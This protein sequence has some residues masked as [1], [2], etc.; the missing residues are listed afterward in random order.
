M[1]SALYLASPTGETMTIRP[2]SGSARAFVTGSGVLML[3]ATGKS[4][5]R[6]YAASMLIARFGASSCENPTFTVRAAG[7][8]RSFDRIWMFG[9]VV[10]ANADGSLPWYGSGYDGFRMTMLVCLSVVTSGIVHVMTIT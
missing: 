7:F 5:V 3:T 10:G 9:G 6:V 8:L 2:Q 1:K 4:S